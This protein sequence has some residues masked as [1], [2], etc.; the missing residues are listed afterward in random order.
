MLDLSELDEPT[1][2]A[3]TSAALPAIVPPHATDVERVVLNTILTQPDGLRVALT[4]LKAPEVFYQPIHRFAYEAAVE[5]HG[6]GLAVDYLS[7]TEQLRTMGRLSAAGG[8]N[9]IAT[10]A[11]VNSNHDT[12]THCLK[13]LEYYTLRQVLAAA[14]QMIRDVQDSTQKPLEIVAK[15]QQGLSACVD[16]MTTRKAQSLNELYDPAF[17]AIQDAMTRKGLVGVPSGIEEIDKVTGGWQGGKFI[18]I[19]ARPGMGKTSLGLQMAR[20]AV[21]DFRKP[22]AF[23]SLEMSEQE[24][25]IKLIALETLCTASELT[26]GQ[27]P[28]GVTLD[29]LRAKSKK[30]RTDGLLF[31]DNSSLTISQLRA[32]A[33]RMKAEQGIEWIM[34]DYV[35]L[36]KGEG[37]KAGNREQELAA[38]SR[39]CKQL[40]KELNIPVIAFAQLSRIV[41]N[42]P[43]KKALLSDLRE[44]GALEQD[45]DMVIFP[46]RA[47]AYKITED[48][49]GNPTAGTAEIHIAKHRGGPTANPTIM[50]D[51]QYGR[52]Y[53]PEPDW[54]SFHQVP[55]EPENKFPASTFE[56]D[57]PRSFPPLDPNKA[58]DEI[59][60]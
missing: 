1:T 57:A 52:F 25:A 58:T 43:D 27:L 2:L 40:A 53:T 11:R 10:L 37:G 38:I 44:S 21:V 16:A 60:F 51:I 22:G 20:N 41:E 56:D 15:A 23:F 54:N 14:Q 36:M 45:A 33:S 24:L 18:I 35:Q 9:A 5:L 6:A 28:D 47:E 8:P 31:D 46:W 55:P 42:R 3:D 19:A 34:I 32:K 4:L 7:V 29:D 59:P 50:C 49:M 48:E 26:K 17:Q 39:G 13:L 30:L 12:E